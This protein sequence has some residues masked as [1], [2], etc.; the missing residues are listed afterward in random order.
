MPINKKT[1]VDNVFHAGDRYFEK[2]GRRVTYEY[3]MI[4]G[5]NDTPNHAQ[6]LSK[7][8]KG[9][10]NHLNLI[11]LSLVN[12][13]L[14]KASPKESIDKFI[15][16]LNKNGIKF[17]M[18]RNLGSDIEASCGQLRRRVQRRAE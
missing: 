5:I 4:D 6:L 11:Q 9:T 10:S 1:G 8:L 3:A 18:R 7:R 12:E 16:I 2:T 14:Y 17:T 13:R 15:K